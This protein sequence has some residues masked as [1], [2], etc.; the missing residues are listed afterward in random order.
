MR[1][2]NA[3]K[4]EARLLQHMGIEVV[5]MPHRGVGRDKVLLQ[6]EAYWMRMRIGFELFFVNM[7]SFHL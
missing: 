1:H 5:Q 6:R 3:T 2:Y 7:P 4:H